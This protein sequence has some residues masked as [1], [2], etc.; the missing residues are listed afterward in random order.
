MTGLLLSGIPELFLLSL[1]FMWGDGERYAAILFA[2]LIHE[3]GHI[4]AAS[5]LGVKMRLCRTGV[6]GVSLKYDFSL[7]SPVKEA[8]ICIAGPLTGF[9]ILFIYYKNGS[10]SYFAGASAALAIFNLMPISYLDGGCFLSA[11]L[12]V[13]MDPDTV[14]RISRV[15]SVVFTFIL[16]C[17]AVFM[18]LR[19]GGDI[20]VMAAAIYLLYRLFS[21]Y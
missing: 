8:V 11:L 14:W 20:S 4:I 15:L 19:T 3:L 5:L 6:S 16:W 18:M 17:I 21:E 12:S 10:I 9:L 7:I 1:A 2:A 13:F